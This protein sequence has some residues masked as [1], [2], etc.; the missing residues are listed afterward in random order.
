MPG[1]LH[2]VGMTSAVFQALGQTPTVSDYFRMDQNIFPTI[3]IFI[4]QIILIA[5]GFFW[6]Q[7]KEFSSS[8]G[9]SNQSNGE[10][11]ILL[12]ASQE[13]EIIPLEMSQIVVSQ[14]E[15][16]F[17]L[18]GT[19][20][21]LPDS[22]GRALGL[23]KPSTEKVV[24]DKISFTV[25]PGQCFGLLGPNGAGKTTTMS[26]LTGAT[27][28]TS[29]VATIAGFDVVSEKTQLFQ[30][31]GYCPQHDALFDDFSV[32]EHLRLFS[33]IKGIKADQIQPRIQSFISMLGIEE[34]TDKPIRN[35]SGGTKR[36]VNFA[37]SLIG[38]PDVVILDEPSTGF[39]DF[40][41]LLHFFPF[42][43][44]LFFF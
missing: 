5:F 27:L 22:L 41:L 32:K 2:Y 3:I 38:D 31:L 7:R 11:D 23:Q 42:P 39:V 17:P 25:Q 18:P 10:Y 1:A 24:V 16:K 14:L 26:V 6:W 34:H 8:A 21:F 30:H 40:F 33:E 4:I 9:N 36:K 13:G 37:I 12:D 20:S 44:I 43:L 29:G 15:K 35:L 19:R 28:P